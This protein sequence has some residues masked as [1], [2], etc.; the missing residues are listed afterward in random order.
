MHELCDAIARTRALHVAAFSF[1]ALQTRSVSDLHNFI[2][3][4]LE[5][6]DDH[7]YGG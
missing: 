3:S 1:L 4:R 5:H 6:L 7:S 2:L